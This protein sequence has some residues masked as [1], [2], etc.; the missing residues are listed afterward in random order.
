MLITIQRL[1]DSTEGGNSILRYFGE[2]FP[3]LGYI[4]Y[5]QVIVHPMGIRFY[6]EFLWGNNPPWSSTDDSYEYW[7]NITGVPVINF[8]T[9]FG[10][11]YIEFGLVLTFVLVGLLF[12]IISYITQKKFSV[13]TLP[14]VFLYMRMCSQS[15]AGYT[16]VNHSSVFQ[17]EVTFLFM[18]LLFIL[19]RLDVNKKGSYE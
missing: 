4:M 15:F 5:D 12:L 11:L 13:I 14:I 9:F 2:S 18:V 1:G 17:F 19:K 10:D 7:G 16:L 3:N 6:P 8:K